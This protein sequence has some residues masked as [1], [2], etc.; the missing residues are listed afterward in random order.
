MI[1]PAGVASPLLPSL[2]EVGG[3]VTEYHG[4]TSVRHF[5]DPSA[6]YRAAVE[7]TARFTELRAR[8]SSPSVV[9]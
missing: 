7:S 4:R 9:R 6:E 2:L 8:I 5:G 3:I 1:D